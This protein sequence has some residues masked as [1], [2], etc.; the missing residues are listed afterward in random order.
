MKQWILWGLC[1]LSWPVMAQ[2]KAADIAPDDWA[3]LVRLEDTLAKLTHIVVADTNYDRRLAANN[4]I[5]PFFREALNIPNAF[6]YPFS[7]LVDL[8]IQTPEDQTFR[9][10]TWQ[11]F[12]DYNTYKYFGIIQLNRSKPT[13]YELFDQSRSLSNVEKE[14]LSPERWLGCI[15]YNLKSFKSKDGIRYLLF[16]YN[17]NDENERIK[18]IEVLTVKGGQVRFGAPIFEV[19]DIKGQKKERFHR[20]VLTYSAEA[21]MRLN[22]DAEMK[23]I[24]H[25]H[26]QPIASKNKDIPFVNV[27]DGTYEAFQYH[28]DGVWRHIDQ[29]E[30][31]VLKEAPRP[32]P[33]LGGQKKPKVVDKEEAKNFKFPE[34]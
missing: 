34:N 5:L 18:L 31:Q 26:L 2:K 28:K 6:N 12:E 8:S 27:P 9:V 15:Y 16:G 17:A 33:V 7:K 10:F 4:Q 1:A 20:L 22:Y 32:K 3:R 11:F 29:L 24:V 23:M 30:T 14:P 21:S 13:F 25:D 19:G